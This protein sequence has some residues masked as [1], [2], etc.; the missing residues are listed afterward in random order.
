VPDA[1]SAGGAQVS[2]RQREEGVEAQ[3]SASYIRSNHTIRF[4]RLPK[5]PRSP[6]LTITTTRWRTNRPTGVNRNTGQGP[7]FANVDIRLSKRFALRRSERLP[8]LEFNA[9]AF[10]LLNH[11]NFKNFV[12]TLSSPVFG[13]ANGALPAR[14]LQMTLRGRF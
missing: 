5:A 2:Q 11:V 4:R 14:Q 7:G 10:N 6:D 3:D 1:F 8:Y 9:D 13:H 12:G